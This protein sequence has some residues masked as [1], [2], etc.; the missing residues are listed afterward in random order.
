MRG[1]MCPITNLKLSKVNGRPAVCVPGHPK[2]NNRGYVLRSRYLME[3]KLG[4]SLATREQ[5]HHKDG[6]H[7][8]D[9]L[10]NLQVLSIEEHSSLH[11]VLNPSSKICLPAR[12][13]KAA[14]KIPG[15]KGINYKR[16]QEL[17]ARNLG[18]RRIARIIDEPLY[19]VKYA[20]RIIKHG[21]EKLEST[22]S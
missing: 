13:T 16:I 4:R 3:Q 20:C 10:D 14:R 17:V 21:G 1:K 5:V 6:N 12:G 18:Y 2:S 22:V 7:V 8:N 9:C 11:S 15:R 19:S